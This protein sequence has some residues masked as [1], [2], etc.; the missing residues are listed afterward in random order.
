[1]TTVSPSDP[2]VTFVLID[3]RFRERFNTVDCL[4]SLDYP[5]DRY[6][7]LWIDY[8]QVQDEAQRR[9]KGRTNFR[10]ISLNREG[11]Y[12]SS[13]CFN[14]GISA[15]RGDLLVIL[16]ADVLVEGVSLR[17]THRSDF[18]SAIQSNGG[19]IAGLL[20]AVRQK[21]ASP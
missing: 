3:G 4:A 8:Y 9:M 11:T 1:M 7:V 20:D 10:P 14:A 21:V 18:A 13:Y 19:T 6:E 16:D 2:I 17:T 12:H 15:A 5:A